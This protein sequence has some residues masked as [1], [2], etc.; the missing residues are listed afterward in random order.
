MVYLHGSLRSWSN[1]LKSPIKVHGS[2]WSRCGGLPVSHAGGA[3]IMCACDGPISL[4]RTQIQGGKLPNYHLEKDPMTQPW[5]CLNNW[6]IPQ[7]GNLQFFE[8]GKWLSTMRWIVQTQMEGA[9]PSKPQ[10]GPLWRPA[11]QCPKSVP[12][13]RWPFWKIAGAWKL[14]EVWACILPKVFSKPTNVRPSQR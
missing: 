1:I 12:T 14:T 8:N 13:A 7:H 5:L 6:K 10:P 9:Q 2:S 11:R 4:L 3:P